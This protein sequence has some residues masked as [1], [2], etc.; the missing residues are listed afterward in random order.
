MADDPTPGE[1][2]RM[3]GNLSAQMADL[4]TGQ[5]RLVRADVYDAHRAALLADLRRLEGKAADLEREAEQRE[6][7]RITE[8]SQMAAD[9]ARDR[10]ENRRL[11]WGAVLTCVGAVIASLVAGV[12]LR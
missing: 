10:A 4:K 1:L 12:I 11:I 3:I 6:R 9:R 7:D 2:G 8:K 5:D